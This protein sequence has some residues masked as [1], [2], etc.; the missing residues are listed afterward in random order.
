MNFFKRK[1]IFKKS[2]TQPNPNLY[3]MIIFNS[4]LFLI[5]ISFF[6]GFFFFVKINKEEIIP[7]LSENKQLE[8]ISKERIEKVLDIFVERRRISNNIQNSSTSVVDPSL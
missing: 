8:K 7:S 4:G 6:F 3:W 2:N 1:K 5:I